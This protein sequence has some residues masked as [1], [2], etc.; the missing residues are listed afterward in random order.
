MSKQEGKQK[1]N[2]PADALRFDFVFLVCDY[3]RDIL[4]FI[5]YNQKPNILAP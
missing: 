4:N 5:H 3:I 2:S 1:I